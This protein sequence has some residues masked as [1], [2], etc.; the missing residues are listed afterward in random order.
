[1]RR[2]TELAGLPVVEIDSGKVR[3][4][5]KDLDFDLD[6]GRVRGIIVVSGR[7][8]GFIPFDQIYHV[9]AA[10]VTVGVEAQILPLE[11]HSDPFPLGKRVFSREGRALG[12]IDDILFDGESGSV[13]GYQ[14]TAGL[15]SDFVEGKKGVALTDELV[16][17]PDSIVVTDAGLE[18][19]G[20]DDTSGIVT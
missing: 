16:V 17:G 2:R 18:R 11:R 4:K 13:W 6:K 1:M 14:V 10:A 19:P 20:F 15:L 5:V 12:V 8:E 7:T 3:G 9:G